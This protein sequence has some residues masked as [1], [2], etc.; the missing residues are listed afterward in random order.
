[1]DTSSRLPGHGLQSEGKPY[2]WRQGDEETAP[3]W[4]RVRYPD[5]AY[6]GHGLCSC[7]ASSPSLESDGARKRWHKTH[8]DEIRA[9]A[10]R[11]L[12]TDR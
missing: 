8:K 2:V 11:A 9:D 7:G 3:S 4:H 1:M 6:L 12:E 10:L 5:P